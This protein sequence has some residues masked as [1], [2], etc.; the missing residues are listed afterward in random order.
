MHL[1]KLAIKAND[2]GEYFPV[3]GTCLG[4][5]FMLIAAGNDTSVLENIN[6]IN[7]S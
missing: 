6:S 2:E 7:H 4:F 3:W 5:E 1:Y